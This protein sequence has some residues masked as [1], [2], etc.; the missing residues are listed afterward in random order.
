MFEDLWTLHDHTH[1]L[2]TTH[3]V[4]LGRL[5]LELGVWNAE[6]RIQLSELG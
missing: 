2:L 4:I 6:N 3:E 1:L 5:A